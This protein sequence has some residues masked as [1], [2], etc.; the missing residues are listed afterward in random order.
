MSESDKKEY[1]TLHSEFDG[2]LE[3]RNLAKRWNFLQVVKTMEE[4]PIKALEM[5]KIIGIYETNAF[6]DGV[7]I[8]TS[9]INYSCFPNAFCKFD[10]NGAMI[11]AIY[12]IKE[13]QEIT[14]NYQQKEWLFFCMRTKEYRQKV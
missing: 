11:R 9:R 5:L 2:E 4:D 1:L 7:R 10:Q 8:T 13:G 6:E 3:M 12:D 14:F